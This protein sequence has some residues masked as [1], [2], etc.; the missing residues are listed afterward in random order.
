MMK[1]PS[2]VYEAENVWSVVALVSQAEAVLSSSLH[3]RI[4]AFIY[5]KPRVTWCTESK[6][7][8]FIE[9]WDADDSARC[10]KYLLQTWK[11]L[12]RY[13]GL[14]PEIS[15]DQTELV[16]TKTVKKYLDSF[17]KWSSLLRPRSG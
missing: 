9:N 8:L 2:I 5:F 3:V 6:H 4:M 7:E 10:V 12:S 15:Q 11:V 13:Y 17:D 1:E 14:H 16:Y